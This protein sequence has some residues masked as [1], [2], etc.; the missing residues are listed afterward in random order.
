MK[1]IG[2][3]CSTRLIA[4]FVI[5]DKEYSTIELAGK[6]SDD[7]TVRIDTMF[8]LAVNYLKRKKPDYVYIENAAYL[9]NVKTSF[10][11]RSVVDAVRF[12]CVLNQVPCQTVEITSWKKDVLGNGKAEKN[13]IMDFAIA[14]YG[15]KLITNQD[16]ADA[17]CIA[18]YGLRRI[19]NAGN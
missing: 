15:K 9:Q 16:L 11:I 2:F 5:N 12:A 8:L 13:T 18:A 14:K 4:G 1:I 6:E 10:L 3:D 17:S 7:T 19:G